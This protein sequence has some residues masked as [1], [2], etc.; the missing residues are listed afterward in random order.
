[1]ANTFDGRVWI[2]DTAAATVLWPGRIKVKAVEWRNPVNINDTAVIQEKDGDEFMNLRCEVAGQSQYFLVE[3]W[4]DGLIVPTLA[5][6]KL[7]VYIQ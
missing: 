1:M 2:I 7:Y 5:T 6:G 3:N 4:M